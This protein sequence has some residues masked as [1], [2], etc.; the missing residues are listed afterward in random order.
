MR[1]V[2]I[3]VIIFNVVLTLAGQPKD[4]WQHPEIAIRGDG[5]SIYNATN[6]SFDFFLGHGWLAYLICVLVYVSLAF[7]LVSVLPRMVALITIFSFIF[8]YF[9][10][11]TNWLVVRWHLGFFGTLFYGIAL[12]YIIVSWAFSVL[13]K[14]NDEANKRLRWLMAV[15]ILYDP[16]NTL[17][18]QPAS[19]WIHPETVNE[20]NLFLRNLMIQGWYVYFIV[21]LIY[22]Y[23]MF[24]LVSILPKKL[25]LFFI[26]LNIF[27]HFVGSS[28]VFF[29]QWRMGMQSPV[30]FGIIISIIII[31][32]I[33]PK[34][35]KL[36]KK[37]FD[38]NPS[39]GGFSDSV[40]R[41]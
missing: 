36:N 39:S 10:E 16:I 13:N 17:I 32:F 20:G 22:C 7:M 29:Y 28:C 18:G 23:F 4:F 37:E 31:I 8:G 1:L 12:S 21:D 30:I 27:T 11:T 14:N 25:A 6:H 38:R 24:W 9:F 5:L 15:V 19:Y 26:L 41:A 33:F 2:M 35:S 40:I 3:G 34:S